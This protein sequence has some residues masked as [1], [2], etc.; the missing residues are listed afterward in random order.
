VFDR[1]LP[2]ISWSGPPSR[3]DQNIELPI[4]VRNINFLKI[5]TFA[6]IKGH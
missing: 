1:F 6:W 2:S 3:H 5:E 4:S